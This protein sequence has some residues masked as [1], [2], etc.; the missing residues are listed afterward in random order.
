MAQVDT[1][2]LTS[3]KE[4]LDQ[5]FRT[6]VEDIQPLIVQYELEKN[7][8]PVAVQNE[9]RAIYS[10]LAR[11]AVS[12]KDEDVERNIQKVNSHTK[13]A[14]ID[15]LKYSCI[16]SL[17][18]YVDFFNRYTGVD[19]SYINDGH[20][21]PDSGALYHSAKEKLKA[22]KQIEGSSN[23]PDSVIF[24]HYND[25]YIEFLA[26]DE[27]LNSAEISAE[28]LKHRATELQLRAEEKEQQALRREKRA[29]RITM[30]SIVVTVISIIISIVICAISFGA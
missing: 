26:L 17:D 20:F 18:H 7:E 3:H 8:F 12:E 5:A 27:M 19:L 21:L 6:Y 23:E 22:A 29:N 13:R 15:C 14:F 10:H 24:E 30:V 25:A 28:T 11:A 1:S 9:I 16:I 4:S 2:F